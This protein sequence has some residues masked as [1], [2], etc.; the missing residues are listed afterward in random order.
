MSALK[1]LIVGLGMTLVALTASPQPTAYGQIEPIPLEN[2]TLTGSKDFMDAGRHIGSKALGTITI[3]SASL[4]EGE[5]DQP[6]HDIRIGA[7][8]YA[9]LQNGLVLRNSSGSELV[10]N[11]PGQS[12]DL[13][14][15]FLGSGSYDIDNFSLSPSNQYVNGAD[16]TVTAFGG[17]WHWEAD[18]NKIDGS[19]ATF[20]L[21]DPRFRNNNLS[22]GEISFT[23][24]IS[25]VD[26]T[27]KRLPETTARFNSTTAA[28]PSPLT[29]VAD[30]D[31][32]RYQLVE[33]QTPTIER[34]N[35]LFSVDTPGP[36]VP[37][38][39]GEP[40]P[41][42]PQPTL[43]LSGI[44]LSAQGVS[45]QDRQLFF[46]HA[47]LTYPISKPPTISAGRVLKGSPGQ[48]AD[49][50]R[51]DDVT[52]RTSGSDEQR[53]RIRLN[54]GPAI[55]SE[56]GRLT[57]N[58]SGATDFKSADDTTSVRLNANFSVIDLSQTGTFSQTVDLGD[59]ITSLENLG[60]ESVQD[61]LKIRYSYAVVENNSLT[62]SDVTYFTIDNASSAGVQASNLSISREHSTETHTNIRTSNSFALNN[63]STQSVTY[64]FAN[65]NVFAEGLDGEVPT[66][67]TTFQ[68]HR[69]NVQSTITR[70][71]AGGELEEDDEIL[72]SNDRA[73]NPSILQAETYVQFER[74]G[75]TKWTLPELDGFDGT[76]A[77]GESISLTATFD[78]S[79][80]SASSLGRNYR[81]RLTA[82]FQDGLSGIF[83]ELEPGTGLARVEGA[84][85]SGDLQFSL[86]GS[87]ATRQTVS[88]FV[89]R[90]VD[91][92]GESGGAS[93]AA[94]TSLFGEGINLTNTV[95]NSSDETNP[96]E[97]RVI[98]SEVLT[99]GAQVEVSFSK[100]EDALDAMSEAEGFESLTSDIVELL[101]L[102]GMLHVIDLSIAPESGGNEIHWFDEDSGTWV[103]AILGNS[104]VDLELSPG[105]LETLLA[106]NRFNG[107]Y[108]SYLESLDGGG[109]QL[110]A[111]G[112][113]GI[114]AWAVID[115][116]S[117]FA[118]SSVPEP[119]AMGL[120][121]CVAIGALMRR[122]R[123]VAGTAR[124]T[125]TK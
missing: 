63:S 74:E 16:S 105:G 56:D 109:P 77:A 124:V 71:T 54:G 94:G 95:E 12:H 72:I 47:D 15:L 108:S 123:A 65:G 36:G 111:Y 23:R 33:D 14:V 9:Y 44:S 59:R 40:Q 17:H 50:S 62:S 80:L 88:Y 119:S 45:L 31:Q 51:T 106:D 30:G 96:T 55:A 75:S 91:L 125:G 89:E 2:R 113:D 85:F 86:V 7:N 121:G 87:D 90:N 53:T 22:D 112:S 19:T 99:D 81:T 103:N 35:V 104:N 69:K 57:A 66:A 28:K 73:A 25:P 98:D 68:A 41:V 32:P 38:A 116:N 52:I 102:D 1:V 20:A 26:L 93:V 76:L 79:G 27:S 48:T 46:D 92:A 61:S 114:R 34:R 37:V 115:H 42:Q 8:G 29:S 107:S 6:S 122:R 118:V 64:S 43:D 10:F 84:R 101:G 49:F 110:G 60:G 11:G 5:T 83:G 120:L 97:F 4:A 58:Y 3:T 70:F 78:D 100:L 67:S 24:G 13:D 82:T 18:Y 39:E 117:S 21:D